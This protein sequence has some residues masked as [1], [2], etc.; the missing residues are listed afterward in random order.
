MAASRL[1]FLLVVATFIATACTTGVG[2]PALSTPT[3]ASAPPST[4]PS[5]S[6]IA[7][8]VTVTDDEGTSVTIPAR[9]VKI[10]S[11]TPATT[12]TLF[13]LGVG[14]RVVGKVEDIANYPPEASG[15]PVVATNIAVDVEKI[16]AL[17]PDLVVSGGAGLTQGDAVEQLRRAKVPVLVSYPTSIS[18]AL[19]GIRTI[20]KVVGSAPEAE[21]LATSMDQRIQAMA[22]RV[23]NGPKPRTFYEIDT[24]GGIFTPPAQSIYGEMLRLAGTEPISGDASYS[25]SLEKLVAADPEVIL[26]G[27]AAYGATPELVKARPGWAVMTAV[28]QGRIVPVNDIVV[29][30]PGPRLVDGLAGLIRA[31]HPEVAIDDIVPPPPSTA[32]TSAP[33]AVRATLLMAA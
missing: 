17:E 19:A 11:L 29:T 28:K 9:P 23:A 5:P 15:V 18:V 7:F 27:D 24:T 14:S 12:E 25:I 20:G 22:A 16:V 8:P 30:R 31:V 26:L 10:V 32:P 1:R 3:A 4:A 33:S 21:Q 6:P 13:A 2:S